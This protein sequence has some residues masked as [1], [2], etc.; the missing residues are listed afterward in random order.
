MLRRRDRLSLDDL[1]RKCRVSRRTIYRD[2][3]SLKRLNIRILCDHGYCLAGQD[4]LP[5]LNLSEEE[6]EL[7][8][9]CLNYSPLGYSPRMVRK[10][11]EIEAKI[12][13]N[14]SGRDC[15]KLGRYL[16]GYSSE[17]GRL[18]EESDE[19]L[20]CFIGA[21]LRKD[22]L[23]VT[24]KPHNKEFSGL[25]PAGL[26]IENSSWQ[27]CLTDDYGHKVIKIPLEKVSW[28]TIAE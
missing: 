5:E 13:A 18:S 2:L 15:K 11:A 9:F 22:R 20:D 3:V 12:I 4:I 10:L 26:L 23:C 19:I 6:R 28:L 8:G 14:L 24:L 7:L 21:L 17:S 27:L 16:I 25:K 1:S